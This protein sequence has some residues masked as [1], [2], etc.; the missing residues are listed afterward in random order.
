MLS[1]LITN[2][3][4]ENKL[5]DVQLRNIFLNCGYTPEYYNRQNYPE[6]AL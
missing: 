4:S 2:W 1:F 3:Y 5:A 6:M